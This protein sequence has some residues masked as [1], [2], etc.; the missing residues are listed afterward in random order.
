MSEIFIPGVN[1]SVEIGI[2]QIASPTVF[3]NVTGLDQTAAVSFNVNGAQLSLVFGDFHTLF[4][5]L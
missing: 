1:T 4:N 2:N 5:S 3:C